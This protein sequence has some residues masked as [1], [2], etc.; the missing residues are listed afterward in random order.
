MWRS[1]ATRRRRSTC[2]TASGSSARDLIEWLDGGASF[3]VCGDAKAMAKDVRATL[4][5]AYADVKSISPEA[6]RA[7]V[8]CARARQALPAGC[9][10][11]AIPTR[12]PQRAHQG[13][14]R[15]PARHAGRRPARRDHRRDRRGRPAAR[16]I[17]RHVPAGRPRPARRARAQEAG[18]GVRLHAPRAHLRRRADAAAMAARSTASRATTATA[19]CGS[20]RGRP[21]SFTASSS[22]T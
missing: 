15:L 1:R 4:V 22:R 17:P 11:M 5:R 2:S 3:Y 13:G 6:R 7:A 20:P 16:Q 10:L 9:V 19:R 12:C 18:E 14:E 8:A 21:S